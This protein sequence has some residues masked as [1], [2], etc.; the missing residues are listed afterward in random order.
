MPNKRQLDA[1]GANKRTHCLAHGN[2][3]KDSITVSLPNQDPV[4]T[5][6]ER[7]LQAERAV[8]AAGSLRSHADIRHLT[9]QHGCIAWVVVLAP[10]LRSKRTLGPG[11]AK[12]LART[13]D[14]NAVATAWVCY[15]ADACCQRSDVP[16]GVDLARQGQQYNTTGA[17]LTAQPRAHPCLNPMPTVVGLLCAHPQYAKKINILHASSK[18]QK[19]KPPC[20]KATVVCSHQQVAHPLLLYLSVAYRRFGKCDFAGPY[21]TCMHSVH[22]PAGCHKLLFAGNPGMR[23]GPLKQR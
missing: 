19:I 5:E 21:S 18:G 13:H 20:C 15:M 10:G 23:Q 14:T 16:H 3:G 7:W 6:K 17:N 11:N 2:K 9:V 1:Q 8:K 22:G 4:A 12:Q